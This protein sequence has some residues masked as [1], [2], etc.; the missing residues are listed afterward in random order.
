MIEK[1]NIRPLKLSL[2]PEF[3]RADLEIFGINTFR[4]SFT[5]LVFFNDKAVDGESCSEERDSFAGQ[6][7]VFGHPTCVGDEGHC[8]I[9]TG[10][11]RFDDRPSH[12]LTPAFRRVVITDALRRA[13]EQKSSLNVTIIAGAGDNTYEGKRLLEFEGMQIAT[14]V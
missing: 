13:I 7:S 9:P 2:D 6:F 5:A 12:A 8:N 11:R 4:P 1:Y 14:F 3:Q 10:H